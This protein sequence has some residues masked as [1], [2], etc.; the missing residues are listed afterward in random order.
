MA[1]PLL[2]G[3]GGGA[4]V[5]CGIGASRPTRVLGLDRADPVGLLWGVVAGVVLQAIAV[6]MEVLFLDRLFDDDSTRRLVDAF[7]TTGERLL[8]VLLVALVAP[9]A[10]ELFYRGALTGLARRRWPPGV[11]IAVVA[12]IFA[13]SHLNTSQLLPLFVVGC[14]F[15]AL[16]QWRNG[17]QPAIA[18]HMSFNAAGL[19]LLAIDGVGV[20]GVV[21]PPFAG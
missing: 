4:L 7:D 10:E 17:L 21:D 19:T 15:G 1:L 6:G 20:R 16:A 14:G 18:A 12:A 11:A 13:A 5:A 8:L 3:L 9:V 2:V